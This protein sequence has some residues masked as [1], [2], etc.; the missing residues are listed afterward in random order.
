MNSFEMPKNLPRPHDDGLCDHLTGMALPRLSLQ[1]TAGAVRNLSAL[2][3]I[4]VIYFYPMTGKPGLSLPEGWLQIPGAPGC[5]PQSCAFR[6]HHAELRELGCTVFGISTQSPS[7][8]AE[9]AARLDLPF[10]LLSDAKCHLTDAL[11]LPTFVADGL[12]MI[13][14]IT[15]VVEAGRIAKVFYPVFPSDRSPGDVIAWLGERTPSM[16]KGRYV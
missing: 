10:E 2:A 13:K 16:N 8:Q 12:R 6:D 11:R 14:R 3:G 15:L 9:A 7:N 4:V 5:T 1:S